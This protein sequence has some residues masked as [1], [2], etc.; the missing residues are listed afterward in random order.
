MGNPAYK[1]GVVYTSGGKLL[2]ALDAATGRERWRVERGTSFTALAIANQLVYVGNTDR[3]FRAFD[4][5][6][7]EGRWTFEADG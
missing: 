4:D 3:F 6:P 2:L 1:A 7:G 5:Q